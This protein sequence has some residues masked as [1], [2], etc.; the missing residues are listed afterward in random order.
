M[1]KKN[2][3]RV[4]LMLG[5]TQKEVARL[6]NVSEMTY[7]RMESGSRKINTDDLEVLSKELGVNVSIF[8]RD[9]LT[10]S[11]IKKILSA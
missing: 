8:F 7:H 1:V 2:L 9:E 11:V 10:D 3:K 4:R 5:L 6:I